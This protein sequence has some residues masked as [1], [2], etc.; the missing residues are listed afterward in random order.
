MM[1]RRVP[2]C[3]RGGLRGGRRPTARR[4]GLDLP[5]EQRVDGVQP[6]VEVAV[7]GGL[8]QV[9]A[10]RGHDAERVGHLDP[11]P[12]QHR[13]HGVVLRA[14]RGQVDQRALA[15]VALVSEHEDVGPP[16][17]DPALL[18]ALGLLL[19]DVE[20]TLL[21]DARGHADLLYVRKKAGGW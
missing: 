8:D 6:V 11:R 17:D 2:I 1:T 5:G 13:R 9:A 20:V 7:A 19:E 10:V 16:H 15:R 12:A 18:P 14:R 3:V 4:L 21:G